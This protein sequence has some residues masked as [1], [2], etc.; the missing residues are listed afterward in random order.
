MRKTAYT[1]VL[2]AL[3]RF[4]I[5]LIRLIDW[6]SRQIIKLEHFLF[7]KPDPLFQ[8]MLQGIASAVSLG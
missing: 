5:R 6:K 3:A 7:G 8:E 4:P 1:F 2:N